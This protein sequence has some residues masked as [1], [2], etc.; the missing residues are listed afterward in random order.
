MVRLRSESWQDNSDDMKINQYE[1][2]VRIKDSNI[3]FK[4]FFC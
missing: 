1:M 3:P 2:M 4:L